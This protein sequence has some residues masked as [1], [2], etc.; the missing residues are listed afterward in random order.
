VH[1]D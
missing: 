1:T